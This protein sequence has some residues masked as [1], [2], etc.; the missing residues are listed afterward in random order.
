MIH[1][2]EVHFAN[3]DRLVVGVGAIAV[4]Q[5][6]RAARLVEH[7]LET[8]HRR[9]HPRSINGSGHGVPDCVPVEIV[10]VLD[11]WNRARRRPIQGG[12]IRLR[13]GRSGQCFRPGALALNSSS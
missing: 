11:R 1:N 6:A 12:L 9:A 4:E 13:S 8:F 7:T 5:Q 2:G 3:L 10:E